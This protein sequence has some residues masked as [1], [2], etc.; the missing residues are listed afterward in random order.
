MLYQTDVIETQSTPAHELVCLQPGMVYLNNAHR[1]PALRSAVEA[2]QLYYGPQSSGPGDSVTDLRKRVARFLGGVEPYEIVFTNSTTAGINLV[3]NGITWNADDQIIV[4][5]AEH[6]ANLVPWLGSQRGA[7]PRVVLA[8]IG[9]DGVL[10]PDTIREMVCSNTRLVA[11]PHISHLWGNLQPVAEICNWLHSR[12]IWSLVDGAQAAGRVAIDVQEIGC[13]FYAFSA[14]KA[15]M[16]LP[17]IGVL[18]VRQSL[19]DLLTP[20]ICGSKNTRVESDGLQIEFASGSLR[21]EATQPPLHLIASMRAALEQVEDAGGSLWIQDRLRDIHQIFCD[22]LAH[23]GKPLL[24]D[25][26]QGCGILSWPA[27]QRYAQVLAGQLA[28]KKD[29]WIGVGRFGA[30]WALTR[31]GLDT[32]VRV[33][34]HYFNSEGDAICLER[35]L[36]EIEGRR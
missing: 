24:G 33:S 19:I 17:G 28:F 18:Y 31:R 30:D 12:G 8:P 7:R 25:P 27:S 16:G 2:A 14:S 13:D 6:Q 32:L 26:Q 21:L 4:T 22:R 9:P 34:P 29:V 20:S 10:R 11:L 15:L 3:A 35:A 36:L 1:G 23:L 5:D